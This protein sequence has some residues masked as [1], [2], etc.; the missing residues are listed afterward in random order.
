MGGREMKNPMLDTPR[1][2]VHLYCK[3]TGG[4]SWFWAAYNS[5]PHWVDSW[6]ANYKTFARAWC[7]ATGQRGMVHAP[8]GMTIRHDSVDGFG[9][10]WCVTDKGVEICPPV[11][12]G[13]GYVALH[14]YGG[15]K[16]RARLA[17]EEFE[18][19]AGCAAKDAVPPKPAARQRK[20]AGVERVGC[21]LPGPK[22]SNEERLAE[23][24]KAVENYVESL[25]KYFQQKTSEHVGGRD[26]ALESVSI[27][28]EELSGMA[29]AVAR[30]GRSLQDGNLVDF[31]WSWEQFRGCHDALKNCKFESV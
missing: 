10:L 4:H 31:A 27:A 30:M 19:R 24:R 22:F 20:E 8:T 21:G 11:G 16:E 2:K 12:N 5:S 18:K 25:P 28:L 29:R 26:A 15:A 14:F 17:I 6:T 1:V 13:Y 7:K 23:A 3:K 9:G